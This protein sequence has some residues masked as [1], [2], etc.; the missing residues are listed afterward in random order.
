MTQ[1]LSVV[2]WNEES[3]HDSQS[4]I[5]G[6]NAPDDSQSLIVGVRRNRG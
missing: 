1:G 4:L 3:T 6:V 5:V 2:D